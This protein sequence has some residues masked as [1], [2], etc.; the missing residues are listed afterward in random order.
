M[1]RAV[2]EIFGGDKLVRLPHSEDVNVAEPSL[3]LKLLGDIHPSLLQC[4]TNNH[5]KKFCSYK[6][7][8]IL[9]Q[10]MIKNR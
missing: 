9:I 5:S 4:G 6:F 10:R 3:Q 1:C 8:V 2:R 7:F